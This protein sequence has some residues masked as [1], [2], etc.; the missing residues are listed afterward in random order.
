MATMRVVSGTSVSGALFGGSRRARCIT[1]L[2]CVLVHLAELH[3]DVVDAGQA[4]H[5]GL[6]VVADLGPQRAA[7]DGQ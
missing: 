6:H 4:A 3:L 1:M 5:L 2:R 7:G